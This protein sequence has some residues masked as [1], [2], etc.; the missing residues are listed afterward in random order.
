MDEDG[1]RRHQTTKQPR[2][3]LKSQKT[4][5]I[6]YTFSSVLVCPECVNP[7]Q[8]VLVVHRPVQKSGMDIQAARKQSTKSRP[9]K[10]K[11]SLIW[12]LLA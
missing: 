12:K 7:P 2:N 6:H 10:L 11:E 8:H 4:T 5:D 3:I 1:N 9:D